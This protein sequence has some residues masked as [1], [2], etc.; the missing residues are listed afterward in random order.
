VAKI[1]PGLQQ[2]NKR[3]V[4]RAMEIMGLRAAIRAVTEMQALAMTTASSRAYMKEFRQGVTHALSVRDKAFG[5]YRERDQK[6]SGLFEGQADRP[7][8]SLYR[9]RPEAKSSKVAVASTFPSR[10]TMSNSLP[11]TASQRKSTVEPS[12]P[13]Y[14]IW[15]SPAGLC[16]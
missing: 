4:H 11:S 9:R 15:I 8:R 1:P 6:A 14:S 13:P 5:D 3:A 7:Y 2:M 12:A 10:A 16:P